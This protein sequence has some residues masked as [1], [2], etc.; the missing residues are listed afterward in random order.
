MDGAPGPVFMYLWRVRRSLL[1]N[2]LI[3]Y[4]EHVKKKKA[5]SCRQVFDD[6]RLNIIILN[7]KIYFDY[8]YENA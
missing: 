4:Y 5:I 6:R 1:D 7:I 3:E 8:I 2:Q